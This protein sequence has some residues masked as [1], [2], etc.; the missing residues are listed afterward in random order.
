[1]FKPRKVGWLDKGRRGFHEGWGNGVKYLKREWNKK[2]KAE[3]K[4]V[5]KEGKLGQKVGVVNGG[6]GTS[7]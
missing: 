7:S 6:A 5:K 2:R 3:T 1:M 4:N